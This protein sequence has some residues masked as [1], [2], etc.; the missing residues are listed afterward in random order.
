MPGP[1]R[2]CPSPATPS[3]CRCPRRRRSS[4]PSSPGWNIGPGCPCTGKP[5][6]WPWGAASCPIWRAWPQRSTCGAWP[7][8]SGPPPCWPWRTRPWAARPAW[9]SP[10][11]RTWWGPS[12]LRAAWWPAPSFL[13]SLPARHLE[14]GRWELIKTALI[15]GEM[16]WATE[17]LQDGPVKFAWVERALAY[18]A[19]VVHRDPR[20]AGER[21]LL[22]LGHTLGHALE[23]ASGYGLLHGEAVGL[24][25][26]GSCLLAEELG[27]EGLPARVPRS[28]GPAAR[29]SGPPGRPLARLPAP[30]AP[31]QEGQACSRVPPG[32]SRPRRSTAFFR[33]PGNR[34]SSG[35][36]RPRHGNPPMPDS[37]ICLTGRLPVPDLRLSFLAV[38]L[39]AGLASAPPR[40]MC[41]R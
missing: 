38:L 18:K 22:N 10:P 25:L 9:I 30:A 40:R 11:G 3:G 17:M 39:T 33:V 13:E 2:A 29:A 21:R 12:M 35:R 14:N 15:Q 34:R 37:S 16:A 19:G 4:A 41:G 28:T 27:P 5:P 32:P 7:G 20:E 24:G 23:A 1:A 6:W 31:G 26:L 36:W 8:R